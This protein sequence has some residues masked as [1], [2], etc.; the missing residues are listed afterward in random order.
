MWAGA[1]TALTEWRNMPSSADLLIGYSQPRLWE[2]IFV[3]GNIGREDLIC[4]GNGK[5][6]RL[7]RRSAEIESIPSGA[8]KARPS[9]FN[10]PSILSA[11]LV[12]PV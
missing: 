1:Q 5:E 8:A 2:M 6:S 7:S 4:L 11:K 12:R 3:E 9:S 10:N